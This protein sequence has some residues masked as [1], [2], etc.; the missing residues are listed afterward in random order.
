MLAGHPLVKL[1]EQEEIDCYNNAMYSMANIVAH[2]I[3]KIED[4]PAR[5]PPDP[6]IT[7]CRHVTNCAC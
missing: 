3:A 1:S 5:Q 4:A 2:G 7:G 6:N